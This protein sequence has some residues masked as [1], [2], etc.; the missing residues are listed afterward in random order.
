MSTS[1][2]TKNITRLLR[3]RC[4]F[5]GVLGVL[6]S[7]RFVLRLAYKHAQTQEHDAFTAGPAHLEVVLVCLWAVLVCRHSPRTKLG[8]LHLSP[9]KGLKKVF[10]RPLNGFQKS[11]KKHL[12]GLLK[13][14]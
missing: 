6:K 9:L 7:L 13:A 11:F 10:T 8:A 2:H 4:V 1:I 5:W 12:K 14:F 3:D